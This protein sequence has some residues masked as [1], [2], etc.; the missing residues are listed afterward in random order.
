[1]SK[2]QSVSAVPNAEQQLDW[3]WTF[4]PFFFCKFLTRHIK[5]R[6]TTCKISLTPTTKEPKISHALAITSAFNL[7]L[8]HI[9]LARGLGIYE[10]QS[11]RTNH[12][13][14]IGQNITNWGFEIPNGRF[15]AQLGIFFCYSSNYCRRVDSGVLSNVLYS[16]CPD[17]A[18]WTP[19]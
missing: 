6:M 16:S 13:S 15:Y 3:F 18:L 19:R 8:C 17:S 9:K 4:F 10:L 12:Q 7:K 1:M 5:K 11:Q 14:P 2:C